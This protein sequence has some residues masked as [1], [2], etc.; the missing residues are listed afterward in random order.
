MPNTG[1]I[2]GSRIT[3]VALFPIRFS[4]CVK[5]IVVT[6]FPS[7]NGVGLTLV[8]KISEPCGLSNRAF[9]AGQVIFAFAFPRLSISSAEMPSFHATSAMGKG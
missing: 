6:V 9:R 1:P 5:P 8:T 3:Q 2:E 7:P 4:A